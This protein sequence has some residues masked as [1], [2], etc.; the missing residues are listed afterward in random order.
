MANS[1]TRHWYEI[2]ERVGVILGAVNIGVIRLDESRAL[3]VDTGLDRDSGRRAI[4]T[5][6]EAGWGTVAGILTTHAHADHIG[7]HAAVVERTGCEVWASPVEA[8]L[9]RNPELAPA[10]LYGA[11]PPAALRGKFLLAEASPVDHLVTGD[12]VTIGD[13][14]IGVVRLP[15]HSPDQIAYTVGDVCFAADIVF[16]PETIDKY[17]IPYLYS[18]ARHRES[19]ETA[20]V[21]DFRA[22][23]P[24]HGPVLAR[25]PFTALIDH[26]AA[27]LDAV[28]RAV[29]AALD[30]QTTPEAIVAA[31]LDAVG[32]TPPDVAA[33]ALLRTTIMSVVAGLA[34][35][36]VVVGRI[37]DGWLHWR[38][39]D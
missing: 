6:A 24:G 25:P 17:R 38:L 32:A 8:A 33:L 26:N 15:G 23:V 39:A 28:E 20:R 31:V 30:R 22:F 12:T 19:M 11:E 1:Q 34:D 7:G 9:T 37:E 3:L 14:T 16:P 27:A 4:R 5:V 29:L 10:I 13:L 18:V 36:G 21:L 2:D 35:R